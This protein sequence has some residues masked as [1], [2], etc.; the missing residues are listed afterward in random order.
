MPVLM[1]HAADLLEKCV[2]EEEFRGT[3]GINSGTKWGTVGSL[4]KG[5]HHYSLDEKGR[6]VLPPIFRRALGATV[7]VTRGLD[8]CIFVYSPQEWARFEKRL[9]GL[10][11]NKRDFVRFILASAED[12]DLD[13]QGRM[14]LP[15]HLRQYAKIERDAVV[16]GVINRL[17]IWGKENWQKYLQKAQAETPRLAADME[18]LSI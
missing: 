10:A 1:Q 12:V 17:E 13:R 11:I 9:R 4:F 7:V 6:V 15:A 3:S 14:T 18:E 2:W 5:E 16:V 8:E